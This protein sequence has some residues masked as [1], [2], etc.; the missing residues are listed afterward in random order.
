MSES[1]K[2]TRDS[3]IE[4]LKDEMSEDEYKKSIEEGRSLSFEQALELALSVNF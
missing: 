2:I 4:K 1:I 3:I